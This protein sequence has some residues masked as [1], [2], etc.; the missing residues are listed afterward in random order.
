MTYT[1][2]V[3]NAGPNAA[4]GV[5]V[6][7]T[8]P[9]SVTFVSAVASQGSGCSL[10]GAIVNCSLGII[11]PGG[12]ATVTIQATTP[13]NVGVLTNRAT[14]RASSPVDPNNGNNSA[15][16]RT[17]N[18]NPSFIIVAAGALLRAARPI[19]PI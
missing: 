10:A 15:T 2:A 13:A 6:S 7:N 1:L 9:A 11:P 4:L 8:L 14:V 12:Q 19:Q 5:V 18:V 3:S 17:A 16:A